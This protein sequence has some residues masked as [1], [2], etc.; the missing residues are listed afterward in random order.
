[1]AWAERGEEMIAGQID[2]TVEVLADLRPGR[3]AAASR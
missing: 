2:G 3:D 1:M